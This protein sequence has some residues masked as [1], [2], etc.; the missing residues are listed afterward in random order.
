MNVYNKYILWCQ[1]IWYFFFLVYYDIFITSV[2][3]YNLR[4]F[5]FYNSVLINFWGDYRGKNAARA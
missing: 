4:R 5:L 1:Y 2:E 3:Y